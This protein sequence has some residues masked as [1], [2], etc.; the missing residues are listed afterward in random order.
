MQSQTE[1]PMALFFTFL[2]FFNAVIGSS[3]IL[4]ALYLQL[5]IYETVSNC[6]NFVML[7]FVDNRYVAR[8]RCCRMYVARIQYW[9]EFSPLFCLLSGL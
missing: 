8:T 2:F 9:R 7:I 5:I 3:F 6:A 4:F 1:I